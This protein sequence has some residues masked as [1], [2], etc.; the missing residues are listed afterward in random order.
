MA[1][2][3]IQTV[4]SAYIHQTWPMVASYI[5]DALEKSQCTL[6]NADHVLQFVASGQWLLL[7]A[8]DKDNTIKGAATISF[9]NYPLHRV[10]FITTIGGRLVTNRNT[11]AQLQQILKSHGATILQG[12]G[13][14]SIVRL[15]KRYN[16]KSTSALVESL[17]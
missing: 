17:L 12:Y 9:M 1:I 13:R 14:E 4:D 16:I 10:A 2:F 3:N 8:V 15:W 11:Y 6:Y 5:Q 7:V